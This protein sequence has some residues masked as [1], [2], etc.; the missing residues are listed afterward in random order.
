MK[1]IKMPGKRQRPVNPLLKRFIYGSDDPR[2]DGLDVA[3]LRKKNFQ[4][5]W[6]DDDT[7]MSEKNYLISI[8]KLKRHKSH[9]KI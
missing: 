9:L 2:F 7:D 5:G 8:N 3:S 6:L 1:N 4:T